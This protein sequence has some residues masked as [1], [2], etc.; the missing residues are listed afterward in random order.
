MAIHYSELPFTIT[1]TLGFLAGSADRQVESFYQTE[2]ELFDHVDSAV[3]EIPENIPLNVTFTSVDSTARM[4]MDGLDALPV[5][6]LEQEGDGGEIFLKPSQS[7]LVLFQHNGDEYYPYIPGLYRIMVVSGEKPYFSWLRITPKQIN[8][9]QWE[10]MRD[11]VEAELRG[12]AQDLI[13]KSYGLPKDA[14]I[15]LSPD[16]LRQFRVI[17]HRFPAIMASITDLYKK[18]NFAIKKEYQLMPEEKAKVVD[19]ITIRHRVQHPDSDEWLLTPIKKIN[20][21]LP[22][23]RLAKKIVKS[24]IATLSKF[25]VSVENY[26]KELA[27][28]IEALEQE[29]FKTTSTISRKRLILKDLGVYLDKS[30]KMRGALNWF[31]TAPWYGEV[32]QRMEARIPHVMTTDVRYR[33]L[34]QVQRE[35][36]NETINISFDQEYMYQWKRTDKIYEIWGFLQFVKLLQHEELGFVP[37]G[38]WLYEMDNL[39]ED[40]IIPT[41]PPG[42]KITFGKENLTASLVYDGRIPSQSTET[43]MEKTPLYTRGTN[44]RPDGRLDLY[45]DGI[46]IGSLVFDFKYRPKGSIWKEDLIS[47]NA[48]TTTMKQ[49][50]SY[51]SN[52]SSSHLYGNRVN[53]Y[54]RKR[55]R[56]VPEVWALYPKRLPSGASDYY[57]DH[58]VRLVELSPSFN[59]IH[60]VTELKEVIN[61]I[62]QTKE[63]VLHPMG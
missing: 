51:A 38:G 62:I 56:P 18:I 44:N 16:I 10:T 14:D 23:N 57:E 9:D 63:S 25:I 37:T 4:F 54:L 21:D 26:Q 33:T 41:I 49:L 45:E 20:Y 8:A 30:T 46:Y 3:L 6:L 22:E 34:Y 40:I 11:E 17:E 59:N 43:N 42:T 36:N 47:T 35:L 50:V 1:F 19:E 27:A 60:L 13:R 61:D 55:L 53:D 48:Q 52:F 2:Q 31:R 29:R 28:E 24:L 58:S 5:G 12:L 15:K 7:P 39:I 32:N